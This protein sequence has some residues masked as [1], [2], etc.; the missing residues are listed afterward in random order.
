[1]NKVSVIVPV[2]G[3]EA[4]LEACV[5][6][7]LAQSHDNLEI[8]LIDDASPDRCPAICDAYAEK[9]HRVKAF[10][11]KN[12]GA[13]SARNLG[14]DHATGDYICFVDSDDVVDSN[15][16]AHLLQAVGEGDAAVCG[17]AQ[18]WRNGCV[19]QTVEPAGE[20]TGRAYLAQFLKSWRCALIWNKIFRREIV[21]D[22]RFPEGHR[23]DDE[24]FTYQLI[25]NCRKVT[26][27]HEPLYYY[28]MRRGSV[29][30]DASSK[31]Q[32]LQ[33]RVAYLS[34]RLEY[35]TAVAPELG[36]DFLEDML[37][38]FIRLLRSGWQIKPVKRA[39]RCWV[40]H[41]IPRIMAL[42]CSLTHRLA[43]IYLLLIKKHLT[44]EEEQSLER[45][46]QDYF[47]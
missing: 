40:R 15:F 25:A 7:L 38:S 46:V 1:M 23:I 44:T 8:L 22:I 28:R 24:F 45:D 3:V 9:D 36:Q 11:K 35:V 37:D 42:D 47:Q 30:H 5:D 10:H 13:A 14:L 33:D 21:G 31:Q 34:Q 17:Y 43:L 12:G 16:V 19:S 4:Y 20:Y 26:V 2:Y 6:S 29:M 41:N 18:L 27:I 39:I 32:L